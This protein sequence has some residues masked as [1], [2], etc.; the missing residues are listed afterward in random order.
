[1]KKLIGAA[2]VAAAGAVAS[3]D[4]VDVTYTV[5]GSSGNW[6]LDFSVTNNLNPADMDVYFFGVYLDSG[7][8]IVGSPAFYDPNAWTVWDNS[9][10]G[11]S[12]T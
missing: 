7:R 12:N 4:P 8:D 5:S 2:L 10:Y 6:T 9:G 1:M 11:G 3:A